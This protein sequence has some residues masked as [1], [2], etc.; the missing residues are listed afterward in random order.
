LQQLEHQSLN[1]FADKADADV[2]PGRDAD[3]PTVG[4]VAGQPDR[5]LDMAGSRLQA[6]GAAAKRTDRAN[7]HDPAAMPQTSERR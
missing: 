6:H 5:A 4:L 2:P 3:H 7:N 1:R